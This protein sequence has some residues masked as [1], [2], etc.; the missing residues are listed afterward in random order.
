MSPSVMSSITSKSLTSAMELLLVASRLFWNNNKSF[1]QPLSWT[2]LRK[3]GKSPFVV[4]QV[5]W[6]EGSLE[7]KMILGSERNHLFLVVAEP[8]LQP[9]THRPGSV[10]RH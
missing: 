1:Y 10:P 7:L 2:V 8:K 3:R 9:S 5:S 6:E 4:F